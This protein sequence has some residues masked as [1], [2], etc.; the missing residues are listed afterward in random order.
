MKSWWLL[1]LLVVADAVL[2]MAATERRPSLDEALSADIDPRNV[3]LI[4]S[5]SNGWGPHTEVAT[6]SCDGR[7]EIVGAY[8][9]TTA[10]RGKASPDSAL[11]MVNGLLSLNFFELPEEFSASRYQLEPQVNGML[12][13]L[14]ESTFD[15]GTATVTLVIGATRHDVKLN[16]PASGA[17]TALR[18]WIERYAAFM[19]GCRGW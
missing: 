16:Y 18:G 17:P 14:R 13:V 19:K 2:C 3:L 11:A 5:R 12:G 10:I 1:V 8:S 15:A 6:L 9:D 4:V 7:Y